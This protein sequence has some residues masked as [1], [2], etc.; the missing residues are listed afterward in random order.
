MLL[1]IATADAYAIPWEFVKNPEEHGLVNDL[2]T[3]QQH[4]RYGPVGELVPSQYT[5]DT[6]RSIATAL[7]VINNKDGEIFNPV[8][9]AR[10]IQLVYSQDRRRGWSKRFQSYLEEMVD[11]S[12][13]E[14][15]RG[16][17]GRASS[18]G[19]IMG[20]LPLAYLKREED[21]R[22]A[23]TVQAIVTHS[24]TTAVDAQRMALAARFFLGGAPRAELIDYLNHNIDGDPNFDYQR[25]PIEVNMSASETAYAVIHL[26]TEEEP[27]LS[28]ILHRAVELGGD[29]D[30]VAALAVGIASC[31]DEYSRDLPE[32][33]VNEL[34]KGRGK[35]YLKSLDRKLM[36]VRER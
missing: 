12:P 20:C 13:V 26:L 36:E 2:Q 21:V 34:D 9:Y 4:P 28:A 23:A 10:T 1:S 8:S 6:L 27:S 35:Y 3:Y 22:L 24:P 19:A 17:K 25:P 29:T 5:D 7:V 14:F 31:S 11:A 16:I 18:N 32:K 33:L 15:M 30:S